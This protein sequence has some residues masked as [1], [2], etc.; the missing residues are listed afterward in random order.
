MKC[1]QDGSYA[2]TKKSGGSSALRL[3]S[4]VIRT[5][6]A[7][8]GLAAGGWAANSARGVGRSE[9]AR[10]ARAVVLRRALLL[11]PG[12]CEQPGLLLL[13]Q[14]RPR[15]LSAYPLRFRRSVVLL[16]V[17]VGKRTA[18][19][20]QNKCQWQKGVSKV[21]TACC[22]GPKCHNVCGKRNRAAVRHP[23]RLLCRDTL[24]WRSKPD[25]FKRRKIFASLISILPW[26]IRNEIFS[27]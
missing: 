4:K 6:E 13:P 23:Q 20:S 11:V 14:H 26:G 9:G 8:G 1:N 17:V 27:W 24:A 12:R 16:K 15:V 21:N 19:A 5:A 2:H 10:G 18:E 3:S 7:A 22:N 25:I